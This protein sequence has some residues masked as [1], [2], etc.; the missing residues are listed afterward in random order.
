MQKRDTVILGIAVGCGLLAF[1]LVVNTLKSLNPRPHQST[2]PRRHSNSISIPK[3]MRGVTLSVNDIENIPNLLNT[4]GYIDVLGMAPNYIG[5]ME[6]QTIAR[7]TLVV[8]IDKP[9]GD[10][11]KAAPQ[12]IKSITLA[13]SPIAAE[14]VSKAMTAGKIH[15]IVRSEGAESE[16]LQLDMV[17]ITEVIRGV[18]KEK[19]MRV[20]K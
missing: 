3:G 20:E 9:A 13:L 19:S 8:S 2:I 10:K 12:E 1:F 4:G 7:N 11:E 15:L 17:G 18:S 6:L 16:S 5:K 14:V